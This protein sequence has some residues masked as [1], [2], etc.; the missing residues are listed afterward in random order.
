MNSPRYSGP[1]VAEADPGMDDLPPLL[2]PAPPRADLS[3][4]PRASPLPALAR[5][6]GLA[7][8]SQS[9]LRHTAPVCGASASPPS[10]LLLSPP[11]PARRGNAQRASHVPATCELRKPLLLELG[12]DRVAATGEAADL[13]ALRSGAEGDNKVRVPLAEEAAA[14]VVATELVVAAE[15][16]GAAASRVRV[17]AEI[18]SNAAE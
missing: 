13:P 2:R 17:R 12:R 4:A 8:V 1:P 11:A 7:W 16:A 15:L 9:P 14:C 6:P 5:G 18:A 10:P 3:P